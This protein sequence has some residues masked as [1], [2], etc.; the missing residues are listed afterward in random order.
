MSKPFSWTMKSPITPANFIGMRPSDVDKVFENMVPVQMQLSPTEERKHFLRLC[1]ELI[2]SGM[3]AT[4]FRKVFAKINHFF[5]ETTF[6][7][8][9]RI[10]KLKSPMKMTPTSSI[11]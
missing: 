1:V 6:L 8:C 10:Y 9:D 3:S 4:S 5:L 2:S 7:Y 11:V